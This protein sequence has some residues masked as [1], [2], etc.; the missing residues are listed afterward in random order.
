MPLLYCFCY[1]YFFKKRSK[2]RVYTYIKSRNYKKL[3]VKN[4]KVKVIFVNKG[5]TSVGI[6]HKIIR[7]RKSVRITLKN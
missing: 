6:C 3:L 5:S 4:K 7:S 1:V 2:L